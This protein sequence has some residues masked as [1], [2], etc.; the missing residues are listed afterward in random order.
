M[1]NCNNWQGITLLSLTSK[2]FSRI[3]L[4]RISTAVDGILRQEQAASGKASPAST[5]SLS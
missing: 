2:I 4:Q 1:G 3:I 5:T